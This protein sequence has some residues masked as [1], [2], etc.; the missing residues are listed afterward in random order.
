MATEAVRVVLESHSQPPESQLAI[1][2][3][4]PVISTPPTKTS[5]ASSSPKT[6]SQI[7]ISKISSHSSVAFAFAIVL[8]MYWTVE[9]DKLQ[10]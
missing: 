2:C 9:N 10:T 7:K 5:S 6:E 8:N 1:S 3:N 4:T